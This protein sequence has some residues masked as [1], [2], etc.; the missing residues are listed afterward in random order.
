[1]DPT[2]LMSIFGALSPG[3]GPGAAAAVDPSAA[4]LAAAGGPL[5]ILP[6]GGQAPQTPVGAVMPP[7]GQGAPGG[8]DYSKLLAGLTKAGNTYQKF[9]GQQAQQQPKAPNAMTPMSLKPPPMQ[10]GM[11][12]GF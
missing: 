12:Q 9:A 4:G 1:M 3:A 2:T 11:L 8:I 5:S 10:L 6:G 7:G